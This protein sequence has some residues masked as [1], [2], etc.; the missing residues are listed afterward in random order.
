MN[1]VTYIHNDIFRL[2]E[3]EQVNYVYI[4]VTAFKY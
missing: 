3:L 1:N 4:G 2:S